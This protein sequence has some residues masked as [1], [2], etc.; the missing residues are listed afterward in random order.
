MDKA[1]GSRF[2]FEDSDD[3]LRHLEERGYAIVENVMSGE[4]V[5][6]ALQ[7]LSDD[8]KHVTIQKNDPGLYPSLAQSRGAW[9][10]RSRSGVKKAF[11][12]IWNTEDLIVSMDAVIAWS[13]SQR[14]K[15]EGLH[16]DQNPIDKPNLDCI[17]GMVP[18]LKVTMESGGLEVVPG[19][20]QG[21]GREDLCKRYQHLKGK[22]DWCP[23]RRDDY[24]YS[25]AILLLAQPGD[26]ILWDSRTVH[27]GRVPLQCSSDRDTKHDEIPNLIRLACAV[28]MVPRSKA[29]PAVLE[30]RRK[31]FDA[32][33]S[34]NHAPHEAG[35]SSGT[36]HARLPASCMKP[37]LG[38]DARQLL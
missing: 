16:L 24:L 27:G 26:L 29:T 3:W 14:P 34:F 33:A 22:G 23:L 5:A 21:T 35:T 32:G 13:S 19:T 1:G 18:L 25:D 36:L 31:G 9:F 10:C 7:L 2:R 11:S 37:V 12:R 6:H 28:S 8:L 20:H 15:S 17:Q 4:E 38:K 30:A